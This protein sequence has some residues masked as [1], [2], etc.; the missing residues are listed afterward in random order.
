MKL[1]ELKQEAEEYA[2]KHYMK[3]F[4]AQADIYVDDKQEIIDAILHFAEPREKCI[5]ELEQENAELKTQIR[6]MMCCANCGNNH[7]C[8]LK[9]CKCNNQIGYPYWRL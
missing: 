4:F 6:K 2:D 7:D 1:D 9:G 5:A 3:S 8:Q